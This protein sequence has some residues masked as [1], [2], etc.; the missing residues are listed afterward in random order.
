MSQQKETRY[1]NSYFLSSLV[2]MQQHIPK[3]YNTRD[4]F[5]GCMRIQEQQTASFLRDFVNDIA[6]V[7]P[8]DYDLLQNLLFIARS[9]GY[10]E[11]KKLLPLA[12]KKFD[13]MLRI[14]KERQAAAAMVKP[15][16]LDEDKINKYSI[17]ENKKKM[18]LMS[19]TDLCLL[20]DAIN[21]ERNFNISR[22]KNKFAGFVS[23]RIELVLSGKMPID[24]DFEILL[25]KYGTAHQNKL[26]ERI[27]SNRV[28]SYTPVQEKPV[29]KPQIKSKSKPQPKQQ[30]QPV[31]QPEQ[32]KTKKSGPS[33]F[34]KI[35]QSVKSVFNKVK[36]P[37]LIGG[38]FALS[39]FGGK[40]VLDS[41]SDNNSQPAFN[42]EYTVNNQ[43][44]QT[45]V[46]DINDNAVA[47]H[48]DTVKTDTIANPVLQKSIKRL[49]L[50]KDTNPADKNIDVNK[51]ANK[52]YQNFGS[53]TYNV[54][55][56]CATAPYKL[57]DKTKFNIKPSTHNMIDYLCNNN[58]SN[59]QR[60]ELETFVASHIALMRHNM[61]KQK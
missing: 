14:F 49:Q 8:K 4:Y 31:I 56:T 58:L 47:K 60:A 54:I 21:M 15:A 38:L 61:Q 5:G 44:T 17:L 20:G 50:L 43:P 9:S 12:K 10:S 51:V 7:L 57:N 52:L 40:K 23:Y 42:T 32:K 37:L 19:C 26:Y 3:K 13:V 28:R 59:L 6:I 24:P 22:I 39:V 55:L 53:D 33:L 16:N 1:T 46:N 25:K 41:A 34:K 45:V 36:K 2:Q 30:S 11:I 27:I 48:S 29:K 35:G 18:L